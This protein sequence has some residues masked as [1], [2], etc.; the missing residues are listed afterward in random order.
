MKIGIDSAMVASVEVFY[1][2]RGQ[3]ECELSIPETARR[4]VEAGFGVEVLL[5]DHWTLRKRPSEETIEQLTEI[6]REAEIMTT[7][8]CLDTWKPE[9]FREEVVLAALIG[10]PL[11]VVHP[12]VLGLDIEDF[13]PPESEVRDL[14]R[15]A[16]DSGVMLAL[17]NLG[18]T[19]VGSLR[20]A[21]DIVGAEPERTGLGICV[22]VGHANRSC[23]SDGI[24]PE[25]FLKEFRDVILEVHIDDNFGDKDLHLPPGR[26]NIDWPPVI[27]AIGELA[28]DAVICLEITSNGDPIQTLRDSRDFLVSTVNCNA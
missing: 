24:R 28:D 1:G 12:Y 22:D 25:T 27:E 16:F 17:E 6:C 10:V 20:R 26:G 19:G 8:A 5:A 13:T 14:C 7:H 9:A 2:V 3:S 18:K 11:M 23:A 4:V 15:F 21:L